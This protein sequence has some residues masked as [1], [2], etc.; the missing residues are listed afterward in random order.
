MLC[1]EDL[2]CSHVHCGE[3]QGLVAA[4]LHERPSKPHGSQCAVQGEAHTREQQT[5]VG[6][7]LL[8]RGSSPLWRTAAAVRAVERLAWHAALEAL[9]TRLQRANRLRPLRLL[10]AEL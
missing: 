8:L 3:S 9:R 7:C 1:G 10:G 6:T 2:T 4:R 5:C